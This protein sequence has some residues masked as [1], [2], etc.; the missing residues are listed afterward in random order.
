MPSKKAPSPRSVRRAPQGSEQWDVVIVP[1][2][3]STQPGHKRRP[4]LVLSLRA[5]NQHGSTVL[6]MITTAGHHQNRAWPGDVPLT[7]LNAAGLHA[8]CLIR[9]KLFTL[10]NRL[11]VKKIGRLAAADQQ[12]ISGQLQTYLPW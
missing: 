2:P 7:D 9:L 8:P 11:I 3:F 4:A 10:D 1:F 5:F 12:Q 6:A